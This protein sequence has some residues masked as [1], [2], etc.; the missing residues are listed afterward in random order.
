MSNKLCYLPIPP[1]AWSRVQNSCSLTTDI[2][3]DE[4]VQVPYTGEVVPISVLGEKIAM[5][6]KGNILQY[7]ANSSNLTQAQR[8]SKIAQGKWT[9]R[10]TTWATQSTRGYTNPNNSSL[11]RAG[12]VINVAIDPITGAVIGETNA[13]VTCAN[14]IVTINQGLP[15]NG[16]GGSVQEPEIPPPVEPTPESD[17]FPQINEDTPVEP[18]VIQDEGVLICSV[19]ENVCTGETKTTR[20]QQLCNPTSDS[21][22]PGSIELLCWNDGTPTWYPRQ[23]YIMT[24]STNKWP[25]NYK[26]FDSAIRP[27]APFITSITSEGNVVTLTWI[28]SEFCLPVERFDIFQNRIFNKSVSGSVLKTDILVRG[29]N[30]YEYYIVA[31]S[32]GS[33]VR[34]EPSNTVYY[35]FTFITDGLVIYDGQYTYVT[36]LTN[37]TIS[38]ECTNQNKFIEFTL[39]GGGSS[40]GFYGT[41]Q[42]NG[43]GSA[44]GGGGQILNTDK[45]ILINSGSVL[46]IFIGLGGVAPTSSNPSNGNIGGDTSMSGS[47]TAT[48]EN[49]KYGGVGGIGKSGYSYDGG[50]GI[51]NSS[52]NS[53]G[54]NYNIDGASLYGY[55]SGGA[56]GSLTNIN[57]AGEITLVTKPSNGGNASSNGAGN[58]SNGFQ[59]INGVYYGG[60]GGGGLPV[61]YNNGLGGNGGGGYGANSNNQ[62]RPPE[63]LANNT[64]GGGGGGSRIYGGID[65]NPASGSS[66]IAIIRF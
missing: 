58:G 41:S 40:A 65:Y 36:F 45:P 31:V 52:Y 62:S 50:G 15:S 4:F 5:L 28:Q 25:T 61:K 54:G 57:S 9:N 66:G 22:V 27:N 7:K 21:D 49:I 38:F 13:P 59:G 39:V 44:A 17:T 37:G 48:T 51:Y 10:N 55:G 6:N 64:G 46:N 14:T 33:N 29:C 8:Y 23:R 18:I 19:Q 60:G 34:S 16:G 24:N 12:N 32:N 1:R 53:N 43:A 20:S 26:F 42:G 56:A 47:F 63:T 35:D 3:T 30:T 2:G 11:K